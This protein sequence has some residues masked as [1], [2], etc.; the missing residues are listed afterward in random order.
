MTDATTPAM[1]TTT[2]P[3]TDEEIEARSPAAV[4]KLDI[5]LSRSVLGATVAVA[6]VCLGV[7]AGFV[8]LGSLGSSALGVAWPLWVA[9]P[10]AGLV[11]IPGLY[12]TLISL[13]D[14]TQL[15]LA[16]V[17]KPKPQTPDDIA[18]LRAEPVIERTYTAE[19]AWLISDGDDMLWGLVRLTD[20]RALLLPDALLPEDVIETE[21]DWP[22]RFIVRTHEG[23]QLEMS[24]AAADT[25]TIEPG[26]TLITEDSQELWDAAGPEPVE[27]NQLPAELRRVIEPTPS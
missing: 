10:I 20:G 23:L 7:S 3:P 2:R 15:V 21:M 19:A 25:D 11:F 12:L 18:A 1:T 22:R 27:I 13:G 9:L 16:S 5:E 17:R 6:L 4:R 8:A 14:V 26:D 24:E